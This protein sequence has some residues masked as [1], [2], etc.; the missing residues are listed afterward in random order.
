L[1]ERFGVV[2]HEINASI[3][4]PD[5]GVLWTFGPLGIDVASIITAK[6]SVYDDAHVFEVIVDSAVWTLLID[7]WL[8]QLRNGR[9]TAIPDTRWDR[10]AW[11]KP[12]LDVVR[13]PFCNINTTAIVIERFSVVVGY[14][15]VEQFGSTA[16]VLVEPD[17]ALRGLQ[18]SSLV[19]ASNYTSRARMQ[20]DGIVNAGVHTF[21]DVC[22][23]SFR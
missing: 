17:I 18:R 2:A 15:P 12:M 11:E 9:R 21:Y 19:A 10:A 22:T 14:R 7:C 1:S 6:V 3:P 8:A 13:C 23:R 4:G 5:I 16:R 20:G